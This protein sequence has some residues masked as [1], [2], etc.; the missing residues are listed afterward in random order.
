MWPLQLMFAFLIFSPLISA[1]L[2]AK[3]GC[4]DSCGDLPIRY[5]FGMGSNCSLNHYFNIDCNTSTDPPKAYLS[6]IKKQVVE[7]NETYIR[8]RNPY[9]ISACYDLSTDKQHSMTVN[10]S[11]TP[12]MFSGNVLTAIGC[13][14][15]LVQIKG[16]SV[17]DGSSAFCADKNGTGGVG[18]Y[19]RNGCCQQSIRGGGKL[20]EAQLID[21][22]GKSLR[23]KLF[24]C[25]YAFMKELLDDDDLTFSYPLYY[26]D[27]T[28]ALLNDDWKSASMAPVVR[29]DWTIGTDN[30]SVAKNFKTYACLDPKSICVDIDSSLGVNGYLC[31]CVQGYYGNPYLSGGCKRISSSIAKAG[32]LDQ[33]GEISIPFPFGVGPNCFLDSSFEVV[34]N[35][36]TNP[37][38][39]YL[40]ALET[41]IVE[42]D[43]SKVVVISQNMAS[44]CYNLSAY[45]NGITKPE[46]RKL[47]IDLLKT[48]FTLSDENWITAI[49]CNAMLVGGV[50]GEGKLTSIG[51]SCAAICSDSISYYNRMQYEY[52]DCNFGRGSNLGDDGCC[53]VP[54]PRGTSYLEAN[55]SDLTGQW[56]RTSF[57]CNYAFIEYM[58]RNKDNNYESSFPLFINSSGTRP[59]LA[60]LGEYFYFKSS[61][62]SLNW[63][64]GAVYCKE[65]RLN[66]TDYVCQNNTDCVDFDS[67]YLCNCSTGYKGN[68][69]LIHGC[70]DIDECSDN[71][72]NTCVSNS[73]CE[74][75]A[76]SYHCTCLKGYTG[77]GKNDGTGCTL[78]PPFNIAKFVVI[79][80]ASALGLLLLLLLCFWLHKSEEATV[81]EAKH[82]MFSDIEYTW[83]NSDH[84]S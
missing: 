9:M 63:R 66:R 58:D 24:P 7:I 45:E 84:T 50:I 44:T 56:P 57:S 34:C 25:S 46:E 19:S 62:M 32:C 70:Q 17:I 77:D 83:T 18:N 15:M 31:S 36:T 22:S 4:P 55:L 61:H 39:P 74:N 37:E 78:L 54:I 71:T 10:L 26:L 27:N 64:I 11:G 13:D 3:A 47:V 8:L 59:D 52:A 81:S 41:E 76:G 73:I 43:S 68:P 49:G 38:K 51:S 30:C 48:Q 67:G 12:Y 29:L 35:T 69:Y 20:M 80:L 42:I 14:D 23:E 2:N 33:C 75:E 79:G 53:R 40:R 5:P 6:I 21:L 28:S 82:K 72:T 1:A 65:A 16:S 60:L